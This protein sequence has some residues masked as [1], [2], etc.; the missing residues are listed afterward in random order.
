[1]PFKKGN[2][3]GKGGARPGAGKPSNEFRALCEDALNE[4]GGID[5]VKSIIAGVKF[6][7][8]FGSASAKPET[9][10]DAVKWL[11]DRAHGKAP[12]E[13]QHTGEG[14]NSRLVFIFPEEDK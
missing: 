13:L 14:L 2:K 6:E 7:G 5:L 4:I 3:H 9:R 12:Q 1:M 8:P 10:L 11:A